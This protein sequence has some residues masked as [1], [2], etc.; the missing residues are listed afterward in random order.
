MTPMETHVARV[1]AV[2]EA[3]APEGLAEFGVPPHMREAVFHK[4]RLENTWLSR[5]LREVSRDWLIAN[6]HRRM[7]GEPV[8]VEGLPESPTL[9]TTRRTTPPR[10]RGSSASTWPST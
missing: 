10:P 6:G 1:A 2:L 8:A 4:L 3:G 7:T 5:A 9:S